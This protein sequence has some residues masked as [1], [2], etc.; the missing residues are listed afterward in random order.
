MGRGVK[1]DP[2]EEHGISTTDLENYKIYTDSHLSRSVCRSLSQ[3]ALQ[4]RAILYIK[5]WQET[6]KNKNKKLGLE[7]RYFERKSGTILR[8]ILFPVLW[9]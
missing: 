8:S 1:A 2:S 9:D 7:L 3:Q 5:A 4:R 6:E